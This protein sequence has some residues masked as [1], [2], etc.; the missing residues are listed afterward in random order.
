MIWSVYHYAASNLENYF[1]FIN[2]EKFEIGGTAKQ[3]ANFD[4][5]ELSYYPIRIVNS[6]F[7]VQ[8]ANVIL[9][10]NNIENKVSEEK[11]TRGDNSVH[12]QHYMMHCGLFYDYAAENI[13]SSDT[14]IMTVNA[15]KFSGTVGKINGQSGA[16]IC[17]SVYGDKENSNTATCTVVLADGDDSSKAITLDGIVV[18]STDIYRP[19]LIGYID[20]YAGLKAN[21]INILYMVIMI[22]L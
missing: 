3:P 6:N 8:Y 5:D 10:N 18:D 2:V 22:G 16:L 12:S 14:Y 4:M 21:Y 20:S 13:V 1:R 15:V 17:G 7:S 11:S 9:Y 19:V